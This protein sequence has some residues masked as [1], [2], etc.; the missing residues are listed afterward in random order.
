MDQAIRA[1][2]LLDSGVQH[3]GVGGSQHRNRASR[4]G[5]DYTSSEFDHTSL[6]AHARILEQQKHERKE[7]LAQWEGNQREKERLKKLAM[8]KKKK[9]REVRN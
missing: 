9:E 4:G 7:W 6:D 8:E 2:E 3:P 5:W 1:A